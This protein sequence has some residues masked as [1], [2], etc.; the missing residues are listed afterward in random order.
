MAGSKPAGAQ[1]QQETVEAAPVDVAALQAELAEARAA[2]ATAQEATS[3]DRLASVL[4]TL[5]EQLASRGVEQ[6]TFQPGE[7]P[8]DVMAQLEGKVSLGEHS[9]RLT[10]GGVP[11]V[12]IAR[13]R[14][15]RVIR[16][17][18]IRYTD[19]RGQLVVT[20]GIHYP[21][22][23]DGRFETDDADVVEYLQSRPSFGSEFWEMGHDP[24]A[25]PDPQPVLDTIMSAAIDLDDAQ[26]AEV[27]RVELET[28]KRDVVLNSV[29][30]ARRRVQGLVAPAEADDAEGAVES[31]A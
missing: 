10:P 11:R 29:R 17:S 24:A 14:N 3:N 26:L 8:G 27:E 31:P 4:E 15:L 5:G 19:A 6:A 9:G 30:A 2:L 12:F 16:K 23:P 1:E 13:G 22:E 28:L 21:F 18:R 7:R 20:E 25:A